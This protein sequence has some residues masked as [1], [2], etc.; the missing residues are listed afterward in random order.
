MRLLKAALKKEVN[1]LQPA[2]VAHRNFARKKS[3]R[4]KINERESKDNACATFD[5]QS[6]FRNGPSRERD[7]TTYAFARNRAYR[8]PATEKGLI[9]AL[10][11]Q[12]KGR[13]GICARYF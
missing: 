3:K 2:T 5:G 6:I 4:T 10:K 11:G 13:R 12:G 1:D 8:R 7:V 9:A